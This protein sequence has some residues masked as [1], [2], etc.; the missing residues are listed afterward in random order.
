MLVP[1]DQLKASLECF[2]KEVEIYPIWLC[3]FL[4]PN[5]PGMLKVDP[6]ADTSM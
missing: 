4:L 6:D 3:P 2:H 1:L 5:H